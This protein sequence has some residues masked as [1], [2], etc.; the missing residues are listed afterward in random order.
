MPVATNHNPHAFDVPS[1]NRA[2]KLEPR[3][4]YLLDAIGVYAKIVADNP[5]SSC[6]GCTWSKTVK[7]ILN[8]IVGLGCDHEDPWMRQDGITGGA[9]GPVAQ[10]ALWLLWNADTGVGHGQHHAASIIPAY[11]EACVKHIPQEDGDG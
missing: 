10:A 7:P 9:H 2:I 6:A 4:K 11:Y 8:K 3:I 5:G 1:V